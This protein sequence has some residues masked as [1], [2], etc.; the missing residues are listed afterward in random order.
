[1]L[2]GIDG[3]RLQRRTGRKMVIVERSDALADWYRRLEDPERPNLMLQE[4]I[5]GGDDTIWMFNGYFAGDGRCLVE[6][7]GRKLRQTP[8]YTGVTS[9]GVCERN[10]VVHDLTTRWMAEL[11]YRGILDI[12]YRF[13]AR[14]GS[15]R[16]LDAN[17]RIGMT[18][19]LFVGTN[20][21]DVIRALY[22]DLT[23]QPV[24]A[25]EPREGR[26]WIVEGGD[27]D[28]FRTYRRD[29]RLGVLAWLRSLRGIEEA[30]HFARDDPRP[31]LAVTGGN[32]RRRLRG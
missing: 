17:P 21:I 12:G 24:Q 32:A 25:G 19:R 7:T 6:F 18:F 11:G 28:S 10:D 31:F 2:K 1:M 26:K 16:V 4:Y 15:Y 3:H 29:G 30:A 9:L 13:D 8:A 14:D 20:G 5:P 22:R 23:G 27:F